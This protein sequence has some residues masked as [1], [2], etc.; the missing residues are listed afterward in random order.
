VPRRFASLFAHGVRRPTLAVATA[1]AAAASLLGAVPAAAQSTTTTTGPD[2]CPELE[3]AAVQFVGTAIA[4]PGN[5]D[6]D[7]DVR[8]TVDRVLRGDAGGSQVV[9]AFGDDGKFLSEGQT[10]V[11][12][13]QERAGAFGL[14]SFTSTDR[15][16]TSAI[17][18]KSDGSSIDTGIFSGMR[19]SWHLVALAF[20]APLAVAIVGL[21][22]LSRP[23]WL[24]Q[25][26]REIRVKRPPRL[27]PVPVTATAS[28]VRT[29]PPMPTS[30]PLV[31]DLR[32]PKPAQQPAAPVEQPV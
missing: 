31:I 7:G 24:W 6:D 28:K 20:A 4:V 17:T 3:P 32:D 8:F 11:V 22:V 29:T 1:V 13:A 30:P 14:E 5:T 25:R 10:Y 16:C 26:G 23:G 18:R 12:S 9:V 27:S 19:G 15:E 2:G 21:W